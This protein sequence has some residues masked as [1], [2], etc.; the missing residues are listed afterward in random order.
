MAGL[1]NHEEA[2]QKSKPYRIKRDNRDVEEVITS[3]GSTMTHF[4][5]EGTDNTKLHHLSSV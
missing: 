4:N 5:A 1:S 3:L 2:P